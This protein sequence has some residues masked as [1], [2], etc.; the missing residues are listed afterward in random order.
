[1]MTIMVMINRYKIRLHTMFRH[2]PT[3]SGLGTQNKHNGH[4][5]ISSTTRTTMN[6]HSTLALLEN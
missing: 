1:M 4:F 6:G 2:P 5:T 3:I